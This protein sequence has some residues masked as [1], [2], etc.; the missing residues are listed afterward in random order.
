MSTV[1]A[2]ARFQVDRF[3]HTKPSSGVSTRE[4]S[5]NTPGRID[6]RRPLLSFTDFFDHNA[7]DRAWR[8]A[9]TYSWRYSS[10]I[11]RAEKQ[12]IPSL[13]IRRA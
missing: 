11:L 4:A 12:S 5:K 1:A 2:P 6:V 10:A 9:V 3:W 13:A 8:H 7:D